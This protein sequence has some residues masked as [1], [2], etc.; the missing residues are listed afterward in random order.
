VTNSE[1]SNDFVSRCVS[2]VSFGCGFGSGGQD[3]GVWAPSLGQRNEHYNFNFEPTPPLTFRTAP[4]RIPTMNPPPQDDHD[5][6]ARSEERMLV[7]LPMSISLK[8]PPPIPIG[9]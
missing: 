9:I 5:E 6:R 4:A 8:S 2:L 3:P 7:A 1:K